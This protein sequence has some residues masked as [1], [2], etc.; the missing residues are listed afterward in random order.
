MQLLCKRFYSS[1]RHKGSIRDSF[2]N[3]HAYKRMKVE[4]EARVRVEKLL[5]NGKIVRHLSYIEN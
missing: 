1:L 4:K 5:I 3:V 2:A